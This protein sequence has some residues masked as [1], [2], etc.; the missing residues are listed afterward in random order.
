MISNTS[1]TSDDESEAGA[2][3]INP[4]NFSSSPHNFTTNDSIA[5]ASSMLTNNQNLDF[6]HIDDQIDLVQV[7]HIDFFFIDKF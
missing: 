4:I 5:G 6:P 3:A 7:L 2:R 1:Y